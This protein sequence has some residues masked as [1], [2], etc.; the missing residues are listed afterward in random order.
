MLPRHWSVDEGGFMVACESV[1][2][3][4]ATGKSQIEPILP[5]SCELRP[6]GSRGSVPARMV[7]WTRTI[8]AICQVLLLALVG[9]G[10]SVA[11]GK[12]SGSGEP[13][14]YA[15]S[16]AA[17]VVANLRL[18]AG[19]RTP[20]IRTGRSW[21]LPC[22]DGAGSSAIDLAPETTLPARQWTVDFHPGS[23]GI[24]S[25]AW[26]CG[27][28]RQPPARAPTDVALSA[29]RRARPT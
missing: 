24:D 8:G 2:G 14:S 15:S 27:R 20:G 21:R 7:G 4:R 9:L 6:S 3:Q 28:W 1:E 5:P 22:E 23:P 18:P 29:A 16:P 12:E 10:R 19:D 17:P 13:R 11:Q 26:I 25:P